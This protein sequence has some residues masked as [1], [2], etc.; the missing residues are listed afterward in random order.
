MTNEFKNYIRKQTLIK[1]KENMSDHPVNKIEGIG[2]VTAGNL[3]SYKV[4]NVMELSKCD[5]AVITVNNIHTLVK[6]AKTYLTS[7]ETNLNENPVVNLSCTTTP[8]TTTPQEI[9]TPNTTN[10]DDFVF[11]IE[12]HAWFEQQIL[13]PDADTHSPHELKLKSAIIYDLSIEPSNRISFICCWV[14]TEPERDFDG[15]IL[16]SMSFSA[17]LLSFFNPDLPELKLSVK[18]KDWKTFPHKQSLENTLTEINI[19]K[20]FQKKRKEN[21]NELYLGL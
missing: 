15:E 19:M 5:P 1:N 10:T 18:Q 8:R 11:L 2:S 6:R 16:C 14:I 7:W 9:D 4:F 12:D 17:Q 13:I 20:G 21:N 3:A